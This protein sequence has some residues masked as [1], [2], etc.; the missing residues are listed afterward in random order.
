[1]LVLRRVK[2]RTLS[3]IILCLVLLLFAF[4]YRDLSYLPVIC[5]Q[6]QYKGMIEVA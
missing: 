2:T 4:V 1:M 5:K 3:Q 6:K